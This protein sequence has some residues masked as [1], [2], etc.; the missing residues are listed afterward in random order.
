MSSLVVLPV[1]FWLNQASGQEE[2][3]VSADTSPASG[4]GSLAIGEVST[5]FGIPISTL[6][7]YDRIGLVPA[8]Y[9]RST[10]R[11]YDGAALRRLAYVQ[12]WHADG[13]LSIEQTGAILSSRDRAQRND[14]IE[15]SRQ[16]LADRIARLTEAHDM[17]IHL[18]RCKSDDHLACPITSTYLTERVDAGLARLAGTGDGA[19]E[20]PIPALYR[21]KAALDDLDGAPGDLPEA[22][23]A[24]GPGTNPDAVA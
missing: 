8:S 20:A 18:T 19:L 12:L 23:T 22:G 9:R 1:A 11:Y 5:A 24:D 14:V 21:V 10:V 7:Y 3:A 6:R 15:R 4:D 17:L 16:E 2:V 13:A